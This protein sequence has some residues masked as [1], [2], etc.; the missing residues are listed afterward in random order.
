MADVYR[1]PPRIATPDHA[2]LL[3]S[4]ELTLTAQ[5]KSPKTIERHTIGAR[6]YFPSVQ[7]TVNPRVVDRTSVQRFIADL[8]EG[9]SAP[10]TAVLRQQA[11]KQLSRWLTEDGEQ[12]AD[13]TGG[14]EGPRVD[15]P[16]VVSLTDD[17]LRRLLRACSGKTF[18]DRRSETFSSLLRRAGP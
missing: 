5:R 17:E 11:L 2:A 9:G 7:R 16:V 6:L 1:M 18:R 4:K 8:L 15:V 10:S 12:D 14:P 3:P 13:H